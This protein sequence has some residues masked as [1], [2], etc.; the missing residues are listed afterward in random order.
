METLPKGGDRVFLTE[1]LLYDHYGE[2]YH[3]PVRKNSPT[4]HDGRHIREMSAE[5]GLLTHNIVVR[6]DE[7]TYDDQFGAQIFFSSPGAESLLGRLEGVEVRDAGQGFFLGRYAVHFHLVG[8][9]K[10]SY[11]RKCS[12]H[13]SFNR[14]IAIHGVNH[15]RVRNN[16]A[17]NIRGMSFFTEDGVER[18]TIMEDNLGVWTRALFSLLVVDQTPA[19][20]WFTNPDSHI[21]R[22]VAA[23]SDNFG[24]WLRPLGH[25]DG[26]SATSKYCPDATPL[27]SWVDN[28]A[29]S[30]RMYGLKLQDWQP[31]K[32][33]YFCGGTIPAQAH[34]N[35][36]VL[37]KNGMA[38][39]WASCTTGDECDILDHF[40]IDNFAILDARHSAWET[41][42]FGSE[43]RVENS[44]MVGKSSNSATQ[45]HDVRVAVRNDKY[46]RAEDLVDENNRECWWNNERP[47]RY[48][49]GTN[50]SHLFHAEQGLWMRFDLRSPVRLSHIHILNYN[51]EGETDRGIKKAKVYFSNK[52]DAVNKHQF[53]TKFNPSPYNARQTVEITLQ[54]ATGK[55]D[56]SDYYHL[57]CTGKT[58]QYI[59]VVPT[60]YYGDK[61][62]AGLSHVQFFKETNKRL[63]AYLNECT[64]VFKSTICLSCFGTGVK[65]CFCH[66]NVYVRTSTLHP[67][68]PNR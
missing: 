9:V 11:V 44:L 34:F 43:V 66:T 57:G 29:H 27:G 5:V 68:I 35:G 14:A 24:F 63:S 4:P 2:G 17:F 13:H 55:A 10:G 26:M 23:G 3:V 48:A 58:A 45:V 54:R 42:Q 18:F 36:A 61:K 38:G 12:I 25:P 56:Y 49:C 62:W 40:T 8:S 59:A 31:R 15:L 51:G 16:V 7:Q 50:S 53:D 32:N 47:R 39:I 20:F 1:P 52:Y 33:G 46:A 22:N 19:V 60:E 6:G 64:S 21:R 67:H 41:W 28:V 65:Y 30:T 37:W